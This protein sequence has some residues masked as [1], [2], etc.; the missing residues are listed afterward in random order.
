[1][2][3]KPGWLCRGAVE[4]GGGDSGITLHLPDIYLT[5]V[6]FPFS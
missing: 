1:M 4:G 6:C 2:I 3:A 5:F